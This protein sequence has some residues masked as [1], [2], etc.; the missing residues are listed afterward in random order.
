MPLN[1]VRERSL[2]RPDDIPPGWTYNPSAWSQ[3]VPLVALALGG[4]AVATYLAAYQYRL[5]LT[6]WEPFFGD[7]SRRVLDSSLSFV[8]PISDAALG[9]LGYLADAVTGVIGA[10]SR[11]RTK[12][13]VV[14]LFGILVGPLGAIS[15]ALVIAQPLLYDSWCTFCLASAV[16]SI[17]MIGPAMDEVLASLQYLRR[18][19]GRADAS[20]WSAF[21]GRPETAR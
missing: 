19:A 15:I 10:P 20:V 17:A 12:P 14:V 1:E 9:A 21:W 13:W 11:W 4:A 8:L 16:I 3:R 18:V 5:V 2:M 7:G 6:V